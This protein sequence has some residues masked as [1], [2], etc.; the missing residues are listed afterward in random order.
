MDLYLNFSV[1]LIVSLLLL[2]IGI[3]IFE[4]S[5]TKLQEFKLIA[6]KNITAAL[7]LGGKL[8]G[9]AVVLGAA[10]EY[11]VSLLDMIIW[12][13]IGIVA[14]IIF[15][16]LAEVITIRFSI[17]KAIEEDNRAVGIM[18]FSLSIAVGWVVSKCLTY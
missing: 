4:K 11:S 9:L 14:Q 7:S 1:Y 6:Q 2:L 18:L 13:A 10:A 15:F 17:Q 8:L 16:V 5:T 3:F 12:G